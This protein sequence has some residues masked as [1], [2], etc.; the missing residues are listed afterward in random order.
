MAKLLTKQPKKRTNALNADLP[1]VSNAT[2]EDSWETL[3]W[4]ARRYLGLTGSEFLR[5][6]L[7]G[8]WAEDPDQ[9]GV[10]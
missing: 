10:L 9:P 6:W 5:R 3:E 7:A 4:R 2:A 1:F 8:Q